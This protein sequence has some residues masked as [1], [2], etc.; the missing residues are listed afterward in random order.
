MAEQKA[1]EF[2][3]FIPLLGLGTEQPPPKPLALV[4]HDGVTGFFQNKTPGIQPSPQ[5][6]N[7]SSD[8]SE[9]SG[10]HQPD[11]RSQIDGSNVESP[12]LYCRGD[13]GDKQRSSPTFDHHAALVRASLPSPGDAPAI[14]Q[15][16]ADQERQ[17]Q[18][19]QRQLER[20]AVRKAGRSTAAG[21]VASAGQAMQAGDPAAAPVAPGG[22]LSRAPSDVEDE[23]F[24]TAESGSG[25]DCGRKRR[26]TVG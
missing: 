11:Q 17:R 16:Q 7:P 8:L 1:Q 14:R 20:L 3:R 26:E 13:A 19:K 12:G 2:G 22:S 25:L 5:L 6:A 23:T 10:V 15:F 21:R 4:C 24:R 9:P 18:R